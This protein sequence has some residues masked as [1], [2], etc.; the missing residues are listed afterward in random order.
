MPF[1]ASS[2]RIP[3]GAN[4]CDARVR[5]GCPF[6]PFVW[7]KPLCR[8]GREGYATRLPFPPPTGPHPAPALAAHISRLCTNPPLTSSALTWFVHKPRREPTSRN[9]FSVRTGSARTCLRTGDRV[10]FR[11]RLLF[12]CSLQPSLQPV[13]FCRFP[14]CASISVFLSTRLHRLRSAGLLFVVC[15]GNQPGNLFGNFGH[16]H[17]LRCTRS[18][19]TGAIA[20]RPAASRSAFMR[21]MASSASS[22]VMP[23]PLAMSASA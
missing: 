6:Q 14:V 4:R 12:G 17:C 7:R 1:C 16:A 20:G 8:T 18:A 3:S 11:K 5:K 21:S 2:P 15:A 10:P 23:S 19:G 22:S 13:V 9:A